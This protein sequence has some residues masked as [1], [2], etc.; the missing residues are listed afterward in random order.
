MGHTASDLTHV[1]LI[2]H[3]LLGPAV[4]AGH[5][6]KHTELFCSLAN[7]AMHGSRQSSGEDPL[8]RT[9]FPN[10]GGVG[11]YHASLQVPAGV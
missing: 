6:C 10:L 8:Q 9:V 5:V 11:V 3:A 7:P 4:S 2:G 1:L